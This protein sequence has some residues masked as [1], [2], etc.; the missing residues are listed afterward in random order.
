[1]RG[2]SETKQLGKERPRSGR[3]DVAIVGWGPV[4]QVLAILLGQRGHRVAVVERWPE[5]YPLPR[6]VH[7]D[8]EVGRIL[9]GAGVA[10][11]LAG[12]TV[13]AAVYEWRNAKGETLIRFGRDTE[14][15]LSGWPESSMFCQPEL[16]RILDERAIPIFTY[17]FKQFAPK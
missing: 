6:A 8:H 2:E 10:G 17:F 4:G 11:A 13:P 7:F 14:R 9:Q 12:R 5:P 1:M 3:S 15:S 16:E